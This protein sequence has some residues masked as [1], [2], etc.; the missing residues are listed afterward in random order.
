MISKMGK[1]DEVCIHLDSLC[2]QHKRQS[3]RRLLCRHM[4]HSPNKYKRSRRVAPNKMHTHVQD[5]ERRLA[6]LDMLHSHIRT[7]NVPCSP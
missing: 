5:I 6:V 3:G 7:S 1:I 4:S 2:M